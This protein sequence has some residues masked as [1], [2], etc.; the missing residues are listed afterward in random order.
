MPSALDDSRA[1]VPGRP[2]TRAHLHLAV[3]QFMLTLSGEDGL[4]AE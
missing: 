3:R 1:Q 2:G 4:S